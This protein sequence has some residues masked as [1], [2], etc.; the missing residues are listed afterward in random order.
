MIVWYNNTV[1][2]VNNVFVCVSLIS[3]NA[4]WDHTVQDIVVGMHRSYINRATVCSY[5]AVQSVLP[6][7]TPVVSVALERYSHSAAHLEIFPNMSVHFVFAA[8]PSTVL[9]FTGSSQAGEYENS[10]L[11]NQ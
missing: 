3:G 4:R 9:T 2:D 10:R 1:S 6:P 7:Y 8:F 11:I 5:S